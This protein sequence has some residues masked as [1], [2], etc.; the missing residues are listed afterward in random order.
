MS[1]HVVVCA[2]IRN[3]LYGLEVG[4]RSPPVDRWMQASAYPQLASRHLDRRLFRKCSLAI[5]H[6]LGTCADVCVQAAIVV[7][8]VIC[9]VWTLIAPDKE[10]SW[11]MLRQDLRANIKVLDDAK[12]CTGERCPATGMLPL[13]L[14][15]C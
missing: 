3:R 2:I 13:S 4:C 9:I 10:A 15:L 6:F 11:E 7:S 1:M 5:L 14:T 8:A 12:V